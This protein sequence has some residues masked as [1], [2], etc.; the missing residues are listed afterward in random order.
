MTRIFHGMRFISCDNCSFPSVILDAEVHLFAFIVLHG[1]QQ[2]KKMDAELTNNLSSGASANASF[3][4]KHLF[5]L[6]AVIFSYLLCYL[7]AIWTICVHSM[8]VVCFFINR[9]EAWVQKSKGI[10]CLVLTD[11]CSGI[12]FLWLIYVQTRTLVPCLQCILPMGNY[13]TTQT[14]TNLQVVRLCLN[15]FF[16]TISTRRRGNDRTFSIISQFVAIYLI[17]FGI[18]SACLFWIKVKE[19]YIFCNLQ[20]LVDENLQAV[21][22]FML[23]VL[24]VPTMASTSLY[25]VIILLL[26]KKNKTVAP[27]INKARTLPTAEGCV[28][29]RGIDKIPSRHSSAKR[30]LIVTPKYMNKALVTI[31]LV[32]LLNN[33][34][35]LPFFAT[36]LYQSLHP[37]ETAPIYFWFG[38]ALALQTNSAL[39]PFLYCLRVNVISQAFKNMVKCK[40]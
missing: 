40:K 16:A 12:G 23:T 19:M 6:P 10:L 31:G 5:G 22:I 13:M 39:S 28:I 4:V 30:G 7:I 17:S 29:R 38:S 33:T 37:N 34:A 32:M 2:V 24:S 35:L 15:R 18:N 8:I 21:C 14:A 11:L 1:I 20:L 3:V 27:E 36:L 9:K 26:R 25:F